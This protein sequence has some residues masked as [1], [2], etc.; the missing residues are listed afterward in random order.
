MGALTFLTTPHV[1]VGLAWTSAFVVLAFLTFFSS[2]SVEVEEKSV[3]FDFRL[4]RTVDDCWA[5]SSSFEG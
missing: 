1:I 4:P 3:S 5:E 2:K